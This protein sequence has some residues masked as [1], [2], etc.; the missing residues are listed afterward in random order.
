MARHNF[1]D[2]LMNETIMYGGL[3]LRRCDVYRDCLRQTGSKWAADMAAFSPSH[4]AVDLEPLTLDEFTNIFDGDGRLPARFC[5][6]E[7]A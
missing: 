5:R 1:V 4:E 3:P 2:Q 6:V 7:V